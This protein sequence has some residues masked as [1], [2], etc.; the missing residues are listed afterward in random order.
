[1]RNLC[2]LSAQVPYL[3]FMENNY[4]V[5][6]HINPLTKKVF[7]IGIG[8]NDRI[9][10]AGAKRN[11]AWKKEVY[12]SGGFLFEFLHTGVSK[13]ESLELERF[14]IKKIGLINLTNIVGEEGN[15][16]A[17][18]KGSTPWNKGLTG[19][20]SCAYKKVIVDGITYDS[21]AECTKLLNIGKST[22]YRWVKK[23]KVIYV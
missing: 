2:C 12:S 23:N 10:D 11:K 16:T 14:Y 6:S 8:K 7:Y 3:C 4:Y 17:F 13:S 1:M 22:F 15:S 19:A 9:I 5:Y 21:V 20:Q 18:K